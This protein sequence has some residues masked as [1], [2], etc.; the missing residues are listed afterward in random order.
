MGYGDF[1]QFKVKYLI[2]LELVNESPL[3]IGMG[4]AL[5]GAVDNPVIKKMDGVPYIPGS[6]VKGVLRAEAERYAR[7]VYGVNEVC[8]IL[9]PTGPNGEEKRL[10][11]LREKYEPCVIC[12]VFG[13]PTIA[14]HLTVYDA[15]PTSSYAIEVRRRVSINR[16][17]GGQHPGRLFEV[18]QVDPKVQWDL[19]LEIENIDIS[20]IEENGD[21]KVKEIFNYLMRKILI[22]GIAL[23]GKRSVGLGLV[24]AN[25]RGVK[26]ITI[27]DGKYFSEDV[28][29]TY[30]KILEVS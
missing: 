26:R 21:K 11:E 29:E 20:K 3:S 7:S 4:K 28:T 25:L 15:Y 9:D 6:T 22:E 27:K 8:D 5:W 23:G 12:S 14:S 16:L 24:K 17:T 18:E 2:N 13:G 19:R 30:K 10:Q 1:D